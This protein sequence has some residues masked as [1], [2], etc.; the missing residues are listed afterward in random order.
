M[1]TGN[2]ALFSPRR[3]MTGLVLVMSLVTVACGG[4]AFDTSR[5]ETQG[6]A[7]EKAVALIDAHG[8]MDAYLALADLE[9]RVTVERLDATGALTASYEE[10]H[11]FPVAPPR[12]Y[13]LR[14][15]GSQVLELGQD[16]QQR[17]WAR[18]DGMSRGG[19]IGEAA[20]YQD[21]WLRSV[22]SRA[23]FCL[24]DEDV[25]L[26]LGP[27]GET[28]T[29]TWPAGPDGKERTAV[30]FTEP[31]SGR[32]S[33]VVLSDPGMIMGA[34]MQSAAS[35][36]TRDYQGVTLVDGWTLASTKVVDGEPGMP[37]MAWRI[38]QIRSDNGF[39]DRLY[40]A[41]TP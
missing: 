38:E 27:D 31:A 14:R 39:T 26:A 34:L 17:T 3:S 20:A 25:Q 6:P 10:V 1:R 35:R 22:L 4:G 36:R 16:A 29:A 2:R 40:E 23:P 13:A 32:L 41:D 9:Y 8:G 12:R 5:I 24:A 18:V 15:T 11:R 30:F 33:R 28:L 37:H 7:G 21:L 19:Q